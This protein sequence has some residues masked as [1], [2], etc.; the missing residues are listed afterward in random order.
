MSTPAK[1]RRLPA[2]AAPLWM[3]LCTLALS[4][5]GL[6]MSLYLTLAHYTTSV[7][8]ACPD[9][10]VVNCE[11]VTT[12]PQSMVF[13]IFPVAL[14]GLVFYV[15]M[16]AV[17]TPW[18][19]RSAWLVLRWARLAAL[20]AGIAFV[21]YLIYTELI[22][23]DAICLL[24]TSVHVITLLLFAL[25]VYATTGSSPAEGLSRTSARTARISPCEPGQ[26]ARPDGPRSP[27]RRRESHPG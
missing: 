3:Q 5:G 18:A 15:F 10:G 12:S 4:L 9:T 14:L 1:I 11:K 23:L 7:T 21:L 27:R 22:T 16:V 19:W 13:G 20:V 17:T 8:L 26:S 25:V 2:A 24:C 6:G